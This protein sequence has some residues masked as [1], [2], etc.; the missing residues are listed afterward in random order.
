MTRLPL[1]AALFPML[2]SV[3]AVAQSDPPP[4][5]PTRFIDITEDLSINGNTLNPEGMTFQV[6]D[7][8]EFPSLMR[9]RRSFIPELIES[10]DEL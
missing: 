6:R 7:R 2:V 5:P 8:P 1:L 4:A 3:S 10:A 9:L